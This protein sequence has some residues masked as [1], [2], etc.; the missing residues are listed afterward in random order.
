MRLCA[1]DHT[2]GNARLLFRV[3]FAAPAQGRPVPWLPLGEAGAERL[4]REH[5]EQICSYHGYDPFSQAASPVRC[6]FSPD[7]LPPAAI[8][9]FARQKNYGKEKPHGGTFRKVLRR[10]LTGDGEFDRELSASA[11]T[12]AGGMPPAARFLLR[13]R[14]RGK[15]AAGLRPC[16]PVRR[17]LKRRGH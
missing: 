6:S 4:M 14:N 12:P 11:F 16:T 10:R 17:A 7:G 8:F 13:E 5:N 2:A 1:A 9:L 15:S 3:P